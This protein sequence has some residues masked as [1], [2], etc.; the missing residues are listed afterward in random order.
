MKGDTLRSRIR[1]ST[2]FSF[3]RSGG[4]GGQ[5]VNKRDTKVTARL[6][7]RGLSEAGEAD[8]ARLRRRLANRINSAGVLVIQVDGERS[9]ARNR[10]IALERLEG[11]V[12]EALRPDPKPR[13][14]RQPSRAAE[15]RRMSGKKRR[16]AVKRRRY[17]VVQEDE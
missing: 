13:R 2:Q 8:V 16:A 5:N 17:R 11:L 14:R 15:E 1:E 4:P 3:S 7:L 9:Q 6:D 10:E 12:T